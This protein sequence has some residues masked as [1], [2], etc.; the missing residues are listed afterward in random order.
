MS[1]IVN[2][3]AYLDKAM[4]GW[5]QRID[6]DRLDMAHPCNCILGQLGEEPE[7]A[8]QGRAPQFYEVKDRLGLT[9]PARLGFMTWG[10]ERYWSLTQKWRR[11][12]EERRAS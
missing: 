9:E 12:I 11:L 3:A 7:G 10:D 5:D 2:G 8:T 1:R 4:P 6:L